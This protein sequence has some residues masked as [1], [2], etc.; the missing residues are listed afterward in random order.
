MLTVWFCIVL[1]WVAIKVVIELVRISWALL[2]FAGGIFLVPIIIIGA[3]VGEVFAGIGV[4][5]LIVLA[6]VGLA[7]IL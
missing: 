3:V 7:S 2:L 4:I 6:I 5:I 1:G